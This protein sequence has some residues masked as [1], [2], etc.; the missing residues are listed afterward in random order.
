M[1]ALVFLA[2]RVVVAVNE[3]WRETWC[4]GSGC[5]PRVWLLGCQK[6]GST[7]VSKLLVD[8][9]GHLCFSERIGVNVSAL[10]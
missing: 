8:R 10:E 7:S 9:M 3:D 4:S 5:W 1:G 2:L 6:C